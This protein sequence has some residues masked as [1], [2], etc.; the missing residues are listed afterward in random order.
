VLVTVGTAAAV[1]AGVVRIRDVRAEPPPVTT[2]APADYLRIDNVAVIDPRDGAS[3]PGMTVIARRGR[4]VS[5]SRTDMTD[6]AAPEEAVDGIGLYAVP[7]FNNMHHHALQADNVPLL[8]ASMLAEGVTGFRAMSG[9][10]Q[11]LQHR[12]QHRLPLSRHAPALLALPGSLLM[13]FNAGSPYDVRVEIDR[14]H[15]QGADFIKLIE[16]NRETFLAAMEHAHSLGLRISGHLPSAVTQHQAARSG[17]DCIEHFGTGTT[18]WVACST[19]EDTL[20][21]QQTA[22]LPIPGWLTKIPFAASVGGA[23]VAGKAKKLLINPSAF[24]DAQTLAVT[25]KAVDTFDEEKARRLA[26]EFARNG[27]WQCPTMVRL[28]TQ[29]LAD[30]SVYRTDPWLTYMSDEAIADYR[31]VL[32]TFNELPQAARETY[33]K[34]Y[35]LRLRL[36]KIFHEEKVPMLAGTDGQ[37]CAPGMTMQQEFQ[38]LAKTGL[39]PLDILRMA[40]IAAAKYLGRTDSIGVIA[41]GMEA[42]LV[43]LTRNPLA[44]VRNL[45]AI[46]GV[47]RA[48]HHLT[49]ERLAEI[50]SALRQNTGTGNA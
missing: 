30:D 21:G 49:A 46:S 35:D 5:V 9:S 8:L 14:Q 16:V 34:C 6:R 31:D 40:T 42:N 32:K 10:P 38:E 47:V 17:Y 3:H 28:R 41:P 24:A 11:L 43:L 4:I 36:I 45:G 22:R 19:L 12:S 33:R 26:R 27:T 50:V 48:G 15:R 13:P 39:S 18:L 29:E 20:V 2:F 7:G 44:D 1:G 37:G 25:K 23:L